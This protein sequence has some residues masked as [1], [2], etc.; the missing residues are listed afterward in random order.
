M[1]RSSDV[2]TGRGPQS[3]IV[4]TDLETLLTALY[5]TI[6]NV[7]GGLRWTGRPPVLPRA[8]LFDHSEPCEERGRGDGAEVHVSAFV[9]RV[10]RPFDGG[11]ARGPVL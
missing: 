3:P 10:D 7:W 6:D 5:V 2:L 9:Q 1:D 4:T 11:P 8:C